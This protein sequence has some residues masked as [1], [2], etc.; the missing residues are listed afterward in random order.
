MNRLYLDHNATTTPDPEVRAAIVAAWEGGGGNASS[1]HAEGRAARRR[2]EEAREQVAALIGA[3]PEEIV[4]TSGGT[5]ADNLALFGLADAAAAGR[6]HLVVSAV[7]HPA[8]LRPAEHLRRRGFDVT[9][10]GVD[11]DGRVDPAAA[12][13]ALRPDT[14]LVSVM[15]ANNEVGTIEPVA[16]LADIARARGIPVHTDAVQAAGK[17][18]VNVD[19]LGVDL[20]TLSAHKLYGPTGAG[21]LYVRRGTRLLPLCRGGPQERERRPGTENV[22][23]L[24]GF[25]RACALAAERL[26]SDAPRLER[27]RDRFESAVRRRIPCARINGAGAPRLP[28]TSNISFAGLDGENIA[29][30]LDELGVAVS[31]GSACSSGE[32]EP[33]HVLLA[34]GRTLVEAHAAVRFSFGRTTPEA[35]V[36][37]AVERLCAAVTRAGGTLRDND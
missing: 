17:I 29:Q 19:D 13:D 33:P 3:R 4:F 20:L 36:E 9:F 10:L 8:V 14:A 18:P 6:R 16:A 22:P 24:A 37:D 27:L 1:V 23:A 28:N 31:T 7:E 15:L 32:D 35:A 26:A 12:E 34:M 30:I 25:G 21:A 5:E 11:A 2:L